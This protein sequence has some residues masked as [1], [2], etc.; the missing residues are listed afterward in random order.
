MI[1]LDYVPD[2]VIVKT[3]V[4][5]DWLPHLELNEKDKKKI[6]DNDWLNDKHMRAVFSILRQQFPHIGGMQD[7]TLTPFFVD[8]SQNWNI[9]KCFLAQTPPSAQIHFDGKNHWAMSFQSDPDTVYYIDILGESIKELKNNVQIQLC[10][11]YIKDNKSLSVKVPRVQQQP[12]SHDCGVF[13]IA[14]LVEFCF[15]PTAF[16]FRTC[17]LVGD[18]RKHLL[19]CLEQGAMS[20]F[21]KEKSRCRGNQISTFNPKCFKIAVWCH[22]KLPEFVDNMV[23]C[24]SR[25]CKKWYHK[26]CI[27]LSH[28]TEYTTWQCVSCGDLNVL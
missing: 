18:M 13:A 7:T 19:N 21:P 8:D 26:K 12:N 22:C 27:G 4:V 20:P 16:N 11:I 17:Y 25:K 14:N 10:Q 3:P 1:D 28:S 9:S 23:S 5:N 2:S 15:R 6:L 24:E